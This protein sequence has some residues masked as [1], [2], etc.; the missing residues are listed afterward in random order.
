MKAKQDDETATKARRG[1]RG[2]GR[3]YQRGDVWWIQYSHN[4]E[5]HRE[6]SESTKRPVAVAL[7]KRRQEEAGKGRPIEDA[8]KVKLSELKALIDADY[9]LQGHRS[10]KR[11]DQ[12]WAHHVEFFGEMEKAIN[13]TAPRL[14]LYVKRR[15]DEDAA[16]STVRNELSALKRA[17][18][19]ARKTGTLLPNECPTFPTISPSNARKGFFERDEHERVRA[20]LP[21]DEG[22]VA[23]F[24]Y[25]TGW[26]KSEVLGLRWSNV[27]ENA[28][29][30][31]I[32]TTKNDESRTLPYGQLP[33]LFRLIQRRRKIT[34]AEQKKRDKVVTHVFHRKG[35][36]IAYFRRSWITACI[37]AGLGVEEKDKAGN[38]ID[39]RAFRIP[40]DYR[41]SAARNLSRAGVPERVIM[42]VCGWKTRSV[43]D[44]YNIVNEADISAGLA[45]LAAAPPVVT[46]PKVSRMKRR[47]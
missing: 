6:S 2:M 34:N 21:S 11:L 35:E 37:A 38:V 29:V 7:L 17:F 30:I 4:G 16:P 23:E 15:I 47:R 12:S 8:E 3:I 28:R 19:L 24:L 5:K 45:K 41:R 20:A 39:R 14:A 46:R 18:N 26:R 42:A 36:P 27:D 33:D 43:F 9:E 10:T 40:H 25:W 44:R 32:D 1:T 31:R 13:I 22:D